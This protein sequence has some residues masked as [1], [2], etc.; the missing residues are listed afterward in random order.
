[1]FYVITET[2]MQVDESPFQDRADAE[3][4]VRKSGQPGIRYYV[5]DEAEMAAYD[6]PD[7]Q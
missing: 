2:G 4:W 1:M 3:A 7:A 5:L 6:A